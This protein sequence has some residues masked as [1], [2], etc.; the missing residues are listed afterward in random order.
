MCLFLRDLPI[1]HVAFVSSKAVVKYNEHPAEFRIS[2]DAFTSFKESVEYNL[3]VRRDVDGFVVGKIG[4]EVLVD[5]PRFTDVPVVR[6]LELSEYQE[7]IVSSVK[8][9]NV[10]QKA[11]VHPEAL[12]AD[13][14]LPTRFWLS[15]EAITVSAKDGNYTLPVQRVADGFVVGKVEKMVSHRDCAVDDF[16]VVRCDCDHF[17]PKLF[18]SFTRTLHLMRDGRVVDEDLSNGLFIFGCA[19]EHAYT[20]GAGGEFVES[21]VKE[22]PDLYRKLMAYVSEAEADGRVSWR[23][24]RKL[25]PTFKMVNDLLHRNGYRSLMRLS[26]YLKRNRYSDGS[27]CTSAVAE[28][29]LQ[30]EVVC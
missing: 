22:N 4:H 7:L 9:L 25:F 20:A 26:W 2:T 8:N 28:R 6:F 21:I 17:K 10:G 12:F 27:Y 29:S 24:A 3:W 18:L 16:S 14:N 5:S 23:S 13:G 19:R 1:G 30:I 15:G 11:W